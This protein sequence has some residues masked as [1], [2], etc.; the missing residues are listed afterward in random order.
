LILLNGFFA[1][2]ELALV[3]ARKSRLRARAERGDGGARVALQLLEEPTRLLSSIQIGITLIGILTG[4][5]S[6][7]VFGEHLARVLQRIPWLAGYAGEVAFT[8]VVVAITYLSL[9]FGELVP[10]RIALAHPDSIAAWVARPML[11]MSHLTAPLVWVLQTSTEAV[12]R[13]LPARS[14]P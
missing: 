7:A 11:W 14:A 3:S 2:S 10:K 13:T 4:V 8:L 9:I 5:Y 12:A 1:G 6:G